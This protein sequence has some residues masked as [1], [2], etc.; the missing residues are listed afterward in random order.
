MKP[1]ERIRPNKIKYS[2]YMVLDHTVKL[3]FNKV[4]SFFPVSAISLLHLQL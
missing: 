1:Q 4:V 3:K 2:D